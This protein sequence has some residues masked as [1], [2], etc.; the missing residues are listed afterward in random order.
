MGPY[1]TDHLCRGYCKQPF[2][3]EFTGQWVRVHRVVEPQLLASNS[4]SRDNVAGGPVVHEPG[5]VCPD[6]TVPH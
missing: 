6:R 3:A 4:N 5:L 2:V 1:A